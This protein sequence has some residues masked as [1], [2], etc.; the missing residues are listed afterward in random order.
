[1]LSIALHML[2]GSKSRSKVQ[3]TLVPQGITA[4]SDR[5]LI[6]QNEETTMES[7]RSRARINLMVSAVNVAL[8]RKLITLEREPAPT[9]AFEYELAG[10]P[11]L[12]HIR[13]AG[14]DEVRFNVICCPTEMG[15]EHHECVLG[16]ELHRF[17]KAYAYA[18][19]ERR[20]GKYLQ[21]FA[22][23]YC[24]K[25][26]APTLASLSIKP[27]GFGAHPTKHGY[28]FFRECDN[29]FGRKRK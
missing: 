8:E 10:M 6:G 19:L 21:N 23:M 1:M 2:E 7:M 15:R 29:V 25:T 11:V 28:D 24:A 14:F 13:D 9:I 18:W 5:D 20:T 26:I 12:A 16:C 4:P 27:L 3:E 22:N 17:G